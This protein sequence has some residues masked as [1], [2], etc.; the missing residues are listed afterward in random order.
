MVMSLNSSASKHLLKMNRKMLIL[1]QDRLDLVEK[2][3][4][5]LGVIDEETYI[6]LREME[7]KFKEHIKTINNQK[8]G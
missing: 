4:H 5:R 7:D 6:G 2:A 8:S 3:F 1:I